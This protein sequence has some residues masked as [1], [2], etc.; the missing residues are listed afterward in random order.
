MVNGEW[1]K[2]L[3]RSKRFERLSIHYS[4]FTNHAF[5]YSE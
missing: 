1:K 2:R 4:P 5:D 3:Q